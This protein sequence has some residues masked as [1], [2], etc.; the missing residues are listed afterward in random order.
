MRL[1]LTNI[2]NFEFFDGKSF[3]VS[4]N[5]GVLFG[6]SVSR[7]LIT[8]IAGITNTQFPH[9]FNGWIK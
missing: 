5:K 1:E 4:Q 8:S 7:R 6:A 3:D 2:D 9:C